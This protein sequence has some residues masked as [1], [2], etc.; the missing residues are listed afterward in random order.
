M[1]MWRDGRKDDPFEE[2]GGEITE[3]NGNHSV[4]DG[5]GYILMHQSSK[6]KIDTE[7]A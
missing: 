7:R 5:E 4:V 1:R 3:Y 6:S 2:S